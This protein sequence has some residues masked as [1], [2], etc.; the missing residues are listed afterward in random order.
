MDAL[1]RRFRL[2]GRIVSVARR[3]GCRR[4]VGAGR[5]LAATWPARRG[6]RTRRSTRRGGPIAA[7]VRPAYGSTSRPVLGCRLPR[8]PVSGSSAASQERSL[9]TLV[10]RRCAIGYA[11]PGPAAHLHGIGAYEETGG[12]QDAS[13][14]AAHARA[15][16]DELHA[17]VRSNP[18]WDEVDRLI[19][20][21]DRLPDSCGARRI[22]HVVRPGA[23]A[24]TVGTGR[25]VL[26][27]R[28]VPQ[29]TS[30]YRLL[31]DPRL[32]GAGL[33]RGRYQLAGRL[34]GVRPG[35]A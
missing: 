17:P 27:F 15:V 3:A 33:Q 32:D 30:V 19:D 34:G 23:A 1:M 25:H 5:T 8:L 14:R 18:S 11:D 9:R 6:L 16:Q 24:P 31:L 21:A 20:R 4:L 13:G 29:R 2:E 22:G 12:E 35:R 10:S 7:P 28:P 26:L